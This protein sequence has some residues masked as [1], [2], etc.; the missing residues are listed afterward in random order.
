MLAK[1]LH[2]TIHDNDF[3]NSLEMVGRLL[4]NIFQFEEAYPNEEDLPKLRELIQNIWYGT[5]GI[6][7]LMEKRSYSANNFDYLKP[8]LEFV[9]FENIPAWDNYESIYIPMFDGEILVR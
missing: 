1:Y 9:S 7:S 5:Y 3:I 4:Q 8:T 6:M 2:I